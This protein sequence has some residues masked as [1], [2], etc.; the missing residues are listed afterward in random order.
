VVIDDPEDYKF[1]RAAVG[2]EADAIVS[3]DRHLLDIGK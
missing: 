1:I 3:N 2:G